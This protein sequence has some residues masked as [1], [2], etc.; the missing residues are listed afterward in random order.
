M[1]CG[2]LRAYCACS[3]ETDALD[4]IEEVTV[5]GTY[6]RSTAVDNASSVEVISSDYISNSGATDV[7]EVTAKWSFVSASENNP[8]AF[9]A[10]ETQGTSNINL[11]GLGL[12]STLVLINGKRD[13]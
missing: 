2:S 10:G 4:K 5:T 9:T 1:L 11:V 3:Q 12:S 13:F 7:G 6:L 8:D